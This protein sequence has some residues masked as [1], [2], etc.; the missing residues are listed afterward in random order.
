M[1]ADGI[2]AAELERGIGQLSGALVLGLEDTGSRMSRLGRAEIV[3][4]ELPSVEEMLALIRAVTVQDVNE[5]AAEL[6]AVP[7]SLVVVG[8]F[9]Q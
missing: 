2:T 1:A 3:H 8:P 4:G 6:A 9:E 5:L 7:R